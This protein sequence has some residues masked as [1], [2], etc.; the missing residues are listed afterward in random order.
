MEQ[1]KKILSILYLV[2]GALNLFFGIV[3]I[4]FLSA[5]FPILADEA[6]ADAW[7]VQTLGNVMNI[8]IGTVLIIYALPSFIGA[9]ALLN[10]KRWGMI[11]LMVL[12]CFKLFIFPV[13]TALGIYTIWIYIEEQKIRQSKFF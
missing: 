2:S 1:H 12:G 8:I 3:A 4:A 9:I 6:G 11:L 5:L 13:G 7:K 10:D